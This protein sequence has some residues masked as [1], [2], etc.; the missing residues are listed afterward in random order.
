MYIKLCHEEQ[1][2]GLGS[3][4]VCIYPGLSLD[5]IRGGEEGIGLSLRPFLPFS[6]IPSLS[7]L[8]SPRSN[9]RSRDGRSTASTKTIANFPFRAFYRV[10]IFSICHVSLYYRPV[11]RIFPPPTFSLFV[12]LCVF[13]LLFLSIYHRSIFFCSCLY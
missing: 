9:G 12:L 5:E 10:A 1:R 8:H 4:V 3:R 2:S 13:F 7:L 11:T 6:A